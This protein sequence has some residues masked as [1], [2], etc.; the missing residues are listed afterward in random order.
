MFCSLLAAVWGFAPPVCD[1]FLICFHT[2]LAVPK[3]RNKRA[4]EQK[5]C[6]DQEQHSPP[7][8]LPFFLFYFFANIFMLGRAA[9]DERIY[10]S[11]SL[12]LL[13]YHILWFPA[14][15]QSISQAH[16]SHHLEPFSL[17]AGA[18]SAHATFVSKKRDFWTRHLVAF[19]AFGFPCNRPT[20]EVGS[21]LGNP[22]AIR[23]MFWTPCC[24]TSY[25]RIIS[26]LA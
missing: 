22:C 11:N 16:F 26:W 25:G 5:R 2:S 20:K 13:S 18:A 7:T 8:G 19:R 14:S 3:S 1:C 21:N 24:S 10:W 12:F 6:E 23:E 4:E 15:P 17:Q 9:C